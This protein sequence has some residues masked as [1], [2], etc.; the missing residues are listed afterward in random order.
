MLCIRV[1]DNLINHLS[2]H[3]SNVHCQGSAVNSSSSGQ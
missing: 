3:F 2:E 1:R